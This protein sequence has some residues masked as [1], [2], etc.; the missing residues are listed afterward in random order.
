MPAIQK[1]TR[2][3]HTKS[4]RGCLECKRRHKKCDEKK[5]QCSNCKRCV[6]ECIWPTTGTGAGTSA[7]NTPS[8]SISPSPSAASIGDSVAFITGSLNSYFATNNYNNHNNNEVNNLDIP[9]QHR[10]QY[11]YTIEDMKLLHHYT[12]IT[13][14]TLD[15]TVAQRPLW[16]KTV[17][18]LGFRH[19]FLLH[20]IL[21]I[22]AIHLATTTT[23]NNNNSTI[24]AEL[25][26]SSSAHINTALETFRKLLE[27]IHVSRDNC[28]ALFVFSC[29]VVVYNFAVA[30]TE[31]TAPESDDDRH[32][33]GG[34]GDGDDGHEHDPI[35]AL[36]NSIRLVRG[37]DS[38]LKPHWA[39]LITS[40]LAPVLLN[41]CRDSVS[42]S[43]FGQGEGGEGVREIKR[44]KEVVLNSTPVLLSQEDGIACIEAI[45]RLA[46]IFLE[47]E[48]A[49]SKLTKAHHHNHEN[50]CESH[51]T[52]PESRTK[53]AAIF[54]WPIT[55]R[56][57]FVDLIFLRHP[58]VLVI[59][60]HFAV[61][62]RHTG[63]CWW[64]VGWY[65]RIIDAVG[66]SVG[67][68][69]QEWLVWPK[70]YGARLEEVNSD[71]VL[72][73]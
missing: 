49:T 62:L 17:V 24:R 45:D 27:D 32:R 60:A 63:H 12:S 36:L 50:E 40:E 34:G 37:V 69:Y 41:G 15:T 73:R 8:T 68:E 67:P 35:A 38:V 57:R 7:S 33:H 26:R 42:P 71:Q 11:S 56:D 13:Y 1:S 9:G 53:L 18:K 48:L 19:P 6:V 39:T 64:L 61:L 22:S 65:E 70:R 16:Q 31:A 30:Q 21:A 47:L 29:I 28:T 52:R 72:L 23:N 10:Q 4:R 51:R 58:V 54:T 2:K 43:L 44:L 5:P 46:S 66:A 25:V 59:V 3:S 20:G 14:A 55:L